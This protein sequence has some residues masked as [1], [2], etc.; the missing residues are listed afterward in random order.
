[1]AKLS[2][3][4]ADGNPAVMQQTS[5]VGN[6]KD[7]ALHISRTRK[8][9]EITLEYNRESIPDRNPRLLSE[10]HLQ[11]QKYKV[12]SERFCTAHKNRRRKILIGLKYLQHKNIRS[13]EAPSGAVVSEKSAHTIRRC[14]KSLEAI[15]STLGKARTTDRRRNRECAQNTRDDWL[16]RS[17]AESLKYRKRKYK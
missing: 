12:A 2:S 5:M 13:S 11:K 14:K 1:M 8:N 10:S 7:V 4:G 17:T 9:W 15:E 6:F 16:D 3:A